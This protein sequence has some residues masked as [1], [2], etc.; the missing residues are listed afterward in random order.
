MTKYPEEKK[1]VTWGIP[2]SKCLA[3][4]VV[5]AAVLLFYLFADVE[6]IFVSTAFYVLVGGVVAFFVLG[7]IYAGLEFLWEKFFGKQKD[8][9][10]LFSYISWKDREPNWQDAP[11]DWLPAYV[12]EFVDEWTEKHYPE[13]RAATGDCLR[14]ILAYHYR[15][16]RNL[17]HLTYYK[18]EHLVPTHDLEIWECDSANSLLEI[19]W[20]DDYFCKV[21]RRWYDLRSDPKGTMKSLFDTI[22]EQCPDQG[23]RPSL[24][25]TPL[26]GTNPLSL[27][28]ERV[29]TWNTYP[30]GFGC[31]RNIIVFVLIGCVVML[32]DSMMQE[33]LFLIGLGCLWY[34]VVIGLNAFRLRFT[35][36]PYQRFV[37]WNDF[38]SETLMT[39]P[40]EPLPA[41]IYPFMTAW[42]DRFF[43]QSKARAQELLT[44]F[45][46]YI[47]RDGQRYGEVTFKN[48]KDLTPDIDITTLHQNWYDDWYVPFVVKLHRRYGVEIITPEMKRFPVTLRELFAPILDQ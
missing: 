40:E 9:E 33:F 23:V 1:K 6:K 22:A 20:L 25:P 16:G 13:A 8:N 12:N 3:W 44:L 14:M 29:K 11:V 38:L 27:E 46:S 24:P 34:G 39:A 36:S 43:P 2:R 32:D 42:C 28:D 30:G 37:E 17:Y 10:P 15:D 45:L 21:S 19:D 7:W 41:C 35:K 4:G 5:A 47:Y 31:M 26:A 18:L 48:L